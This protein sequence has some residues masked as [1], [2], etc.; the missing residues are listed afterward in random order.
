MSEPIKFH[1]GNFLKQYVKK[2]RIRQSGWARKAGLNVKTVSGYLKQPTMWIETL[3]GICH[4]LN[5]NFF[6]EIAALLPPDMPPVTQN[7]LQ[8]RI[9]E[10]EKQKSDLELQVKTLEKALELVGRK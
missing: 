8:A 4:T 5:Y 9:D 3:L 6:K 7:P 1:T 2:N 10:L